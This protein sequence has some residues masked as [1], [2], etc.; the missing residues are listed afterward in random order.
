[1]SLLSGL[2]TGMPEVLLLLI[3]YYVIFGNSHIDGVWVSVISFTLVFG[4]GVYGM[5]RTGT[6][7]V[8]KGQLEAALALGYSPNFAFFRIILPQALRHI[9]PGYQASVVSLVKSTAVVGYIAVQDLTKISDIVRSC[10]YEAFFSL[11]ATAILYFLLAWI[12]LTAIRR[13]QL[14]ALPIRRNRNRILRGID[15]SNR[16]V[17]K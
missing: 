13:I 10:T 16:E 15:D 1:M 3:L 12:L 8:D 5:L 11:I 7:A 9:L 2:I 6:D 14:S 4:V 17:K